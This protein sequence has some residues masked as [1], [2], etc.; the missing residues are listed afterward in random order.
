MDLSTEGALWSRIP[1]LMIE[2]LADAV[3]GA[4]LAAVQISR[5]ALRGGLACAQHDG[6]IYNTGLIEGAVAL[7]GALSE[8]DLT[9]GLGLCM[10]PGSRQWLNEVSTGEFAV[11]LPGERHDAVYA[12]GSLYVTASLSTDRLELIAEE[13]GL[14][15]EPRHF[16]RSGVSNRPICAGQ[17]HHLQR[18]FRGVHSADDG[19]SPVSPAVGRL[20]V[21]TMI[22]HMSRLPHPQF[23]R[24]EPRGLARTAAR[25]RDFIHASLDQPLSVGMI[26]AAAG[27]S[28]RT[29]HRAFRFV[30]GETPYTYVQGARLH[31][32]RDELRTAGMASSVTAA[33]NRWG[34]SELGRFAGQYRELFGELPSATQVKSP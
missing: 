20:F 3:R 13:M 34:V 8:Q 11:F 4:G 24:S 27:T 1:V 6:I 2:D 5:G 30:F 33:A 18:C 25:A 22:E 32:I 17:L 9:I 23:V 26:A 7:K 31:R 10:P 28:H 21:E 16:S 14:V 29:L 19:G 12:P 15:L